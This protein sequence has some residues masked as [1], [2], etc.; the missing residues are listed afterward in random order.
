MRNRRRIS[1]LLSVLILARL[2]SSCG[3]DWQAYNEEIPPPSPAMLEF[4]FS[5]VI[6]NSTVAGVQTIGDVMALDGA[7]EYAYSMD[8][9][10]YIY[11]F[12]Y[13]DVYYRIIA[14]V[15]QELSDKIWALDSFNDD[16]YEEKY[17][18]L[19]AQIPVGPIQDLSASVP[20]Q[21]ELDAVIG[22]TGEE[23]LDTGWDIS[24]YDA[25]TG[26]FTMDYGPY[27]FIVVFD[28]D[29]EI[30]E[31]SEDAS[32]IIEARDNAIRP[33]TVRSVTYVRIGNPLNLS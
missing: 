32:Y 25:G 13:E 16:E 9:L 2:L 1:V 29:I 12:V 5:S 24:Y 4:D 8:R 31:D 20:L 22:T 30:D 6:E 21:E 14:Q 11:V 7:E 18:A 28:G 27:E 10:S 26:E 33:L 15:P 17:N 19:I 3:N 23:L